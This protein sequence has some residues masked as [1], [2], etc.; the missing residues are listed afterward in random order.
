MARECVCYSD[1][2]FNDTPPF[3]DL[4][5][6]LIQ[7]RETA[8]EVMGRLF[9]FG[10]CFQLFK[11][12][13][14]SFKGCQPWGRYRRTMSCHVGK[15]WYGMEHVYTR[16]RGCFYDIQG[17]VITQDR[18]LDTPFVSI[19]P[20]VIKRIET[21]SFGNMNQYQE[22]REPPGRGLRTEQLFKRESQSC[23]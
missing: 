14:S 19:P 9:L 22:L 23:S 10:S 1:L 12:I 17:K 3:D 4:E 16:W 5:Q 13:N 7:L 15:Q 11:I 2:K 6:F 8:P 21:S 20:K 18:D